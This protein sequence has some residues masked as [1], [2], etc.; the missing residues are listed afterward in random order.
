MI[1]SFNLDKVIVVPTFDT[2]LKDNTPMVSPEHRLN[3]C[4][5]AFIGVDN[6]EISDIEILRKGKSYTVDT[7]KEFKNIYPD[8][9]LFLIIGA[10][11]F[12]Q[13]RLWRDV[14]SIFKLAAILTVVRGEVFH[15]EL[16]IA[17]E[18]YESTFGARV[19]ISREPICKL[20]STE[21]RNAVNN[22]KPFTHFLEE[23]VSEYIIENGLY[24]YE[25]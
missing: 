4:R 21:I 17:K 18:Y 15:A 10:D 5:L 3:M 19:Y 20:S 22:H 9:D 16:N 12:L 14:Q 23:K 25:K 7:L 13:L 24:G 1:S 11:S 8:D 2:P 6:V